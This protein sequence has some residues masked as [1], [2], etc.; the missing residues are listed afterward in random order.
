M[1]LLH[2]YNISAFL[3]HVIMQVIHALLIS[4]LSTNSDSE[5]KSIIHYHSF[6]TKM[7]IQVKIV[8]F[9][10]FLDELLWF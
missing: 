3:L 4:F 8:I 5:S 1:K 10:T 2:H 9:E 6:W 7:E